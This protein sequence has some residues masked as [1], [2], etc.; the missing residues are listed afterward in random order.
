M[1]F[2]KPFCTTEDSS[3]KPGLALQWGQEAAEHLGGW[4]QKGPMLDSASLPGPPRRFLQQQPD[5]APIGAS[6]PSPLTPSEQNSTTK[7]ASCQPREKST[8]IPWIASPSPSNGQ[9]SLGLWTTSRKSEF[10]RRCNQSRTRNQTARA[11]PPSPVPGGRVPTHWPGQEGA[12]WA[13]DWKEPRLPPSDPSLQPKVSRD[14]ASA[15]SCLRCLAACGAW[16][17]R[18]SVNSGHRRCFSALSLSWEL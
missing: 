13:R 8:G 18:R 7:P 10:S 17:L 12:L 4:D 3:P 15:I 5:L 2:L 14:G 9:K 1:N 6:S 11:S 16:W